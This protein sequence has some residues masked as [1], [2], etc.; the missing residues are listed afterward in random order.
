[1]K[2]Q[3]VDVA[4]LAEY[5]VHLKN[6]TVEDRYTRFCFH[7]QDSG[8]DN[9]ILHMLYNQNDHYL[10]SA[11]S[12]DSIC[13]F[14]HLAREGTDWELAVSVDQEYQ[15]QGVAGRLIKH[16]ITWG[17]TR[18]IHSVFMHCITQNTKIQHLAHKHGL[19]MVE[20]DGAEVTSRVDLPPPDT[21]D[22]TSNFLNEQQEILEKIVDL[23]TRMM[24]NFNLLTYSKQQAS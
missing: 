5:A 3:Q 20:R 13:G 21:M 19:R 4:A 8:I 2:V 10:F 23:Q 22:Y 16:M 6:L 7:I 12:E 15:G 24:K 1:M 17:K 18:G 14:G 11:V 9:L